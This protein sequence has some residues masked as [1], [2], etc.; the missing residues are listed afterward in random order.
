MSQQRT[1]AKPAEPPQATE[2][3]TPAG[4]AG[5]TNPTILSLLADWANLCTLAGVVSGLLGIYFAAQDK[6]QIS[7]AMGVIAVIL[8]CFD[9]PIARSTKNRPAHMSPLGLQLDSLADAICSGVGPAVLVMAVGDWNA[10]LLIPASLIVIAGVTRL[11]YF[12]VYGLSGGKFSGMPIFYNPVVVAIVLLVLWALAPGAAVG[13][14]AAAGF[15]VAIL[16][17]APF[18]VPKLR[19]RFLKGFLVFCFAQTAVLFVYAAQG[20]GS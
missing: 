5:E 14:A 1:Q 16:N 17:V 13:G 6:L 12:N 20:I 19:G 11:A 9:G 15:A 10:F 4:P 2:P 3:A 18:T 7:A 8:D